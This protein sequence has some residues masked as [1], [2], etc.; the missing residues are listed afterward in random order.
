MGPV[1]NASGPE[2]PGRVLGRPRANTTLRKYFLKSTH[3]IAHFQMPF[4]VWFGIKEVLNTLIKYF[5]T[6]KYFLRPGSTSMQDPECCWQ[7]EMPN[8]PPDILNQN[9]L[10]AKE[11]LLI[12]WNVFGHPRV[13]HRPSRTR[14]ANDMLSRQHAR[15]ACCPHRFRSK[16]SRL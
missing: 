2:G 5:L 12:K 15:E 8:L 6:R 3:E 16:P 13:A 11:V 9:L 10:I 7:P 1:W 4:P 14:L